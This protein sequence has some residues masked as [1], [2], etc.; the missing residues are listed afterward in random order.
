MKGQYTLETDVCGRKI[1]FV[2]LDTKEDS[3]DK[4][5]AYRSKILNDRKRNLNTTH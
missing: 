3:V 1:G 2:H 5:I 4:P